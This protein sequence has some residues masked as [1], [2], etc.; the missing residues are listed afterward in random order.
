MFRYKK[1]SHQ[2]IH[3]ANHNG[4]MFTLT[5][6]ETTSRGSFRHNQAESVKKWR[7]IRGKASVQ[8]MQSWA[9]CE[10]KCLVEIRE[11]EEIHS[12]NKQSVD[13]RIF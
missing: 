7:T 6:I 2:A 9:Y 1:G 4:N 12:D 3:C 5:M 10:N 11:D 8:K 13:N